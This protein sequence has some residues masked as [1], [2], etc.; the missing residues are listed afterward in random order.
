MYP[1]LM[2]Q[3]LSAFAD[4][5]VLFTVIAIVMHS[6]H[7]ES[8]YI[9]AVQSAF[10]VAYVVLAP[11]AGE[12]A[13]THAKPKILLQANLLKACGALL[14]LFNVEP[15][16]AYSVVGIGAAIYNPV[17]YG[18]LPELA[19]YDQLVKANSLMEGSTILAILLGMLAGAKLADYSTQGALMACVALFIVSA[20]VTLLLPTG[21]IKKAVSGSKIIAFSKEIKEFFQLDGSS[22]AVLGGGL[23]WLAAATLRVILIAWAPLVLMTQN[24]T[25]IATLTLFLAIGIIIGSA[26]VPRLIPLEH[27]GRARIP[28]YLMALAVLALS[29]TGTMWSA[30]AALLVVG[31][32]GG[33]FIVPVNAV[34]QE[35]GKETIGSG[36]A[37]ALQGFFNNIGMLL[38]VGC[39]TLAAAN[40]TGP[41]LAMMALGGI[42]FIG[43]FLVSL[44]L[45]RQNL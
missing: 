6:P 14:L 12:I 13:D 28:S 4:N 10:T 37:V 8:W 7:T 38:G 22:F 16:L 45:R 32:M 1:L 34:L 29:F 26:I 18:I 11:W 36:R 17:K 40:H 44:S 39:Y 3:F 24:T 19:D 42:I 43:T 2:A 35:L 21:E 27:I 15:I 33:M 9:P 25:E 23:F 31:M 30:R 41:V 5:A 20:L